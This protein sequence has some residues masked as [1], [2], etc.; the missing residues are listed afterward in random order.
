M[1][2]RGAFVVALFAILGASADERTITV[3]RYARSYDLHLPNGRAPA[4]AAPLVLVFHGAGGNAASAK[5]TTAMDA[6]SDRE[7]FIAVFPNGSGDPKEGLAWN[8]WW[9]GGPPNRDDADDVAFARAIVED[10]AR[11]YRVDRKRI[12]ATGFSNGGMLAYRIGCEA[13]DLVAAIAPVA[14]AL[15]SEKCGA[16]PPVSVVAFHGRL[17][18]LVPFDGGQPPSQWD[19]HPRKQKSVQYAMDVWK[20][21]DACDPKPDAERKRNVMH[22]SHR[23]AGGIDVDLYAIED[24]GHDWPSGELSATDAIWAFFK[25]HPRQ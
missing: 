9:W 4:E 14:G 6:K 7:G 25:A 20:K 19:P 16:G 2:R 22:L 1:I 10:V 24:Q 13:G 5:R 3:G 15:N 21:R 18:N 12:F 23:C 8:A 11:A 17:D